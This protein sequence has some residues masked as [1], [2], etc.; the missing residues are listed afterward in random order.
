MTAIGPLLVLRNQ[1]AREAAQHPK[2]SLS[3]HL[4]KMYF[5]DYPG[6]EGVRVGLEGHIHDTMREAVAQRLTQALGS[7]VEDLVDETKFAVHVVF[8]E[9]AEWT[10]TEPGTGIRDLV[11]RITSRV[12]VG[13]RMCRS[14]SWLHISK[15]YLAY[16]GRACLSLAAV[17]SLVRPFGHWFV[18][19]CRRLRE[20][21]HG[22]TKEIESELLA[23]NTA[24][25]EVS[26]V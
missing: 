17:F 15:E 6:F 23:R 26:I 19:D 21:V 14:D 11:S 16:S 20:L 22:A 13:K 18:P 4:R 25:E 1:Y 8:G 10:T 12:L 3:A 5:P 7:L 2:M 24:R 9:S